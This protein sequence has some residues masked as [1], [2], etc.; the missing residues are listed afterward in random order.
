MHKQFLV[1]GAIFA[2]LAVVLGAF[3]AHGLEK[4]TTD[5]VILRSFQTGVQYQLY[6]AFALLI[7]GII[8]RENSNQRIIWAARLFIFGILLFSGSLYLLTYLKIEGSVST[9]VIGPLTPVG[10]MLFVLGW[11]FVVAGITK[12]GKV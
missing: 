7:V 10:G 5:P 11:L 3:G 2:A 8:F 12:K 9:K 1:A 4:I 6:H